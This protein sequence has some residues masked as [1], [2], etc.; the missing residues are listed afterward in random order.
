MTYDGT[1]EDIHHALYG[2]GGGGLPLGLL[3]TLHI[4]DSQSVKSAEKGGSALIRPAKGDQGRAHPRRLERQAREAP[5]E[6]SRRALDRQIHQGQAARG[7][8]DAARRSGDSGLR[9]SEPHLARSRFRLH[10]QME[11]DGRRS[12]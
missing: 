11:R 1:L 4:I 7:W 8:L 3:A 2:G 9:L 5:P 10:S 6:G 12:L